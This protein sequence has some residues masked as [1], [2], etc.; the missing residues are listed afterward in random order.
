M[1]AIVWEGKPFHM[2]VKEKPMPEIQDANDITVRITVSGICGTDLH[3]YRGLFGSR[4][5]PWIMGHEGIGIVMQA[6][7]GVKSLKAGDRVLVGASI[8]CGYC[9]NCI[10]GRQS[11]CLTYNPS[12]PADAFGFGDDAG[13]DLGGLQGTFTLKYP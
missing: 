10:R 1:K 13:R 4:N 11:Y 2:A 12:T 3:T 5:P 9:D 8:S 7:K 6:G